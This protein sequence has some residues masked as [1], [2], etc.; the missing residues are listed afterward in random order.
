MHYRMRKSFEWTS[1][2]TPEQIALVQTSFA[3]IVPAA[4]TAAKPTRTV[5][6]VGRFI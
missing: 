4:D 5:M 2:T 3:H 6:F 1:I